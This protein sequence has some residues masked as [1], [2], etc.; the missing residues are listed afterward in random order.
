MEQFPV[1]ENCL[2]IG[3]ISLLELATQIGENPFYAYDRSV[4]DAQIE[5]LRNALPS[6]IHLHYAMK[7][8]PMPEVVNYLAEHTD[9]LDV[10]SGGELKVALATGIDPKLVSFAGPGKSE[11]ELILAIQSGVTINMESENEMARVAALAIELDITPRVAIRV[12]PDFE[13]KASG[14][15]M[16]GGPKPFGVDAE[17]VPDML[18]ELASLPSSFTPS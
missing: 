13:L 14:M 7:A 11:P 17:R 5:K 15:K 12:N 18:A 2:Q 16:A 4:I 10:A 3:G 8:N 6:D 9:G 1:A